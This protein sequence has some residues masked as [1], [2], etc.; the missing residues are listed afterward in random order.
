[1]KK[2]NKR[3]KPAILILL[4]L[5]L[6]ITFI[7]S[8]ISTVV[9]CKDLDYS[10]NHYLT[11]DTLLRVQSYSITF[12]NENMVIIKAYGL[13]KESPHKSLIIKGRFKKSFFDNWILEQYSICK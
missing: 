3:R 9:R 2:I 12:S 6:L 4:V 7:T 5:I 13:R 11:R 8:K 1:M 10:I